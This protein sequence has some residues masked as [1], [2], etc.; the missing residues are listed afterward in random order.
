MGVAGWIGAGVVSAVPA[1]APA[2]VWTKVP[3]PVPVQAPAANE[4]S[5][6]AVSGSARDGLWLINDSG[7]APDLHFVGTDGTDRGKVRVD[8]VANVDWEELAAFRWRDHPYL[9]IADVGD[10]E[11]RRNS[12]V[13]HCLPEPTLP[14]GG[15]VLGGSVK[16]EWSIE[17]RYPDGPRDCEAV[18]VDVA[19][20][21]VILLAKRTVPPEVYELPLR[22]P[23]GAPVIARKIG[24]TDVRQPPG[25][26]PHPYGSQ[27]TGLALREDGTMAAVVTYVAVFLFPK[28]RGEGWAEAFARNP[29]IL[30]RHGLMQA[31]AIAF[32]RDGRSLFVVSEGTRSPLV[33]YQTGDRR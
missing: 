4:V 17:F 25:G 33:V 12:V 31:E 22:P 8:G 9:L 7:G 16:P 27:P 19:A 32:A 11:G 18:A 28:T 1:A 24:R 15:R 6:L 29:V 10:N 5:G 23:Q 26:L 13:L 2:G 14:A 20:G 3:G 30:P 21:K